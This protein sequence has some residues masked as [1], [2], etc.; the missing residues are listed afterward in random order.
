MVLV[1]PD[2]PYD[3]HEAFYPLRRD[4]RDGIIKPSFQHRVC[5]K[6]ILVCIKWIKK[7]VYF[8]NLEWFYAGGFGLKRLKFK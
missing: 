3:A 8:A 5:E 7:T 4:P 2:I 6:R 1:A